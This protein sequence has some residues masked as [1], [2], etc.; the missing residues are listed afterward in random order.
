[1][2]FK[3]TYHINDGTPGDMLSRVDVDEVRDIS[4]SELHRRV[5]RTIWDDPKSAIYL[6][7]IEGVDNDL[8]CGFGPIWSR[9]SNKVS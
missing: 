1:M 4:F 7:H 8:F 9:I 3:V 5:E 2:N 6:A